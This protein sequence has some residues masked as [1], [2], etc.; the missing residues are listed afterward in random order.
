MKSLKKIVFSLMDTFGEAP[1]QKV[2][3]LYVELPN[4]QTVE[5]YKTQWRKINE[6]K[7]VSRPMHT[8]KG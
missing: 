7:M 8:R 6:T 2:V 4:L 1:D 5:N 3:N